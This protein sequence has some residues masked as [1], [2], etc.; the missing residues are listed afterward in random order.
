MNKNAIIIGASKKGKIAYYAFNDQYNIV[1]FLDNNSQLWGKEFEGIKILSVN[2]ISNINYDVI[3]IAS[4]YYD[5]IKLQLEE[6]GIK[7]KILQFDYSLNGKGDCYSWKE[8]NEQIY[9]YINGNLL[10]GG[11][12]ISFDGTAVFKERENMIEELIENRRIIHLGCC[13]HLSII[14]EKIKSNRWLHSRVT[15]KAKACIGVDI[16]KESILLAS[17]YIDNI[18]Y[19]DILKGIDSIEE[20]QWDDLLIPDVLEHISNPVE[21]LSIIKK[22][23]KSKVNRIIVAVPNA[24]SEYQYP[25][26]RNN[27]EKI[28]SDHRYWFSPYTL[29]KVLMDS[30]YKIDELIMCGSLNRKTNDVNMPNIIAIAKI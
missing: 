28:N 12:A 8:D 22:K 21:F 30:G 14:E 19:G 26:L 15:N 11:V 1:N 13:D 16:D 18:I 25:N 7:N 6:M 23:Y 29:A 24:F 10:S 3:I 20:G 9:E 5:E 2:D 4:A 27:I 17:Q